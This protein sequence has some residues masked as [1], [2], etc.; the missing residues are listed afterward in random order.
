MTYNNFSPFDVNCRNLRLPSLSPSSLPL[1]PPA[2]S[3]DSRENSEKW[4]TVWCHK[5][6]ERGGGGERR[7]CASNPYP[8]GHYSC[9]TYNITNPPSDSPPSDFPHALRNGLTN[10]T[11]NPLNPIADFPSRTCLTTLRADE[12][13]DNA[14]K[15]NVQINFIEW[16]KNANYVYVI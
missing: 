4:K 16:K 14:M 13:S 6:G 7:I 15:T 1:S 11:E 12:K 5:G 3:A 9:T 10:P 2:D 8:R